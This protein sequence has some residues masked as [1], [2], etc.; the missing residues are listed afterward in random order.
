M[1]EIATRSSGALAAPEKNFFEQYSEAAAGS[2]IVGD[3]L[4][5]TKGDWLRGQD[6]E[7]VEVGTRLVANVAELMVGWVKW[8]GGAPSDQRMGRVAEGFSP[9]SRSSLGD[10]EESEWE[11]DE[12]GNARD[13]WQRSNYL[14]LKDEDGEGLLTFAASSKGSLNA[15]GELA[16]AYGKRIRQRPNE[17][18]IIEL[19]VG[20][21]KHKN[22]AYGWIKFPTLKV[23]GW[24]DRTAFDDAL[25]ADEAAN[26][27]REDE[28]EGEDIPFD[29]EPAPEP[30]K[31]AGKAKA[32]EA[33]TA[34]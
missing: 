25:A 18:P 1:T 21:Y 12:D 29:A 22:S 9:P 6:Q 31:K 26:A 30:A 4:K 13:P 14:L 7:D 20:K 27:E 15:V 17:L 23:V 24:V 3:L 2:R 5:F 34:F 16:G 19:G 8:E 28:G 33:K 32:G 11:L 10:T